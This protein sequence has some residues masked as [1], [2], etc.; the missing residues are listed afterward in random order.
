MH[1]IFLL[2]VVVFVC[3]VRGEGATGSW[4]LLELDDAIA[5][6]TFSKA[7]LFGINEV[8]LSHGIIMDI[9]DIN[10]NEAR[11][12]AVRRYSRQAH[13]LGLTSV[14]WSHEFNNI[15]V[16][17]ICFDPNDPMWESR[18]NAYRQ[19]LTEVPE[20][21]GVVLMFGSSEIEP[22]YAPCSLTCDYCHMN[23]T[24]SPPL[25]ILAVP[26]PE[27]RVRMITEMVHD[28]VVVEF[29]K[30]LII[31][32]FIH[33]VPQQEWVRIALS[34]L[35]D[36]T[37]TAMSK[38]VPQDFQPYYPDDWLIASLAPH[39]HISEIDA[40]GEYWGRSIIPLVQCG[41]YLERRFRYALS[42]GSLFTGYTA[43][44]SRGADAVWSKPNEANLF[45]LAKA[46]DAIR[47][48]NRSSYASEAALLEFVN[49]RY[50]VPASFLND[51]AAILHATDD[52]GRKMYYFL[53]FWA[54]EKGSGL[55]SSLRT[56][57]LLI[58]RST[59]IIFLFSFLQSYCI[60]TTYYYY[61]FF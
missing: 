2:V 59:G 40:A 34:N 13:E 32:T 38:D 35:P 14:V 61:F 7:G 23:G 17:G 19:A 41:G 31:R 29:G 51:V 33:T 52:I 20:I 47:A 53:G 45:Y 22:W 56:S 5:N 46:T 30:K 8:Q 37:F 3:E 16:T 44:V 9:D 36:L 10:E 57:D 24:I 43:R 1:S 60:C 58:G 50:S 27:E 49:W 18:R 26:P 48:G 39:D 6:L 28:V 42:K 55:P 15:P 25:S 21:D 12:E 54:L 4:V 11:R